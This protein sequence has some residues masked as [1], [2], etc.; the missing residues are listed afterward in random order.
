[1][2]VKYVD[3]YTGEE[4]VRTFSTYKEAEK[5]MKSL[6]RKNIPVWCSEETV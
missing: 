1:M 2:I 6:V 4:S 5:F 3:I